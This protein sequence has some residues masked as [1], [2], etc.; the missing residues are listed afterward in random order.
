MFSIRALSDNALRW[1]DD[2]VCEVYLKGVEWQFAIF[3]SCYY[4]Y[5]KSFMK[6]LK[7]ILCE[8]IYHFSI[9]LYKFSCWY[10]LLI[11][12][13]VFHFICI[14]LQNTQFL[15]RLV[16]LRCIDRVLL[17]NYSQI[18][19]CRYLR[20]RSDKF[21]SRASC[22]HWILL[23]IIHYSQI[24]TFLNHFF[25]HLENCLRKCLHFNR[26]IDRNRWEYHWL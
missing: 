7:I 17:C 2:L 24:Y 14:G 9:I 25:R 18:L 11:L 6:S 22:F 16:V 19:Q 4:L 21:L 23:H 5:I 3:R 15:I 12:S 13:R 10:I 26:I 20:L 8:L 1:F